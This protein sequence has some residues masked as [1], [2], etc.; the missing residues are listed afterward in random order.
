MSIVAVACSVEPNDRN[1]GTN[2]GTYA[3]D[4]VF[5]RYATGRGKPICFAANRYRSGAGLPRATIVAL[6]M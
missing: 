5:D 1:F 3:C 6:K 4:A 2:R